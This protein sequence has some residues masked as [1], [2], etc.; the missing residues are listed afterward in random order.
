MQ[1]LPLLLCGTHSMQIQEQKHST[2]GAQRYA[3]GLKRSRGGGFVEEVKR[4]TSSWEV[5][6]VGFST[7]QLNIITSIT[8]AKKRLLLLSALTGHPPQKHTTFLCFPVFS[9]AATAAGM[10]P[11]EAPSFSVSH[12][13]SFSC[14]LPQVARALPRLHSHL[15][16][17]S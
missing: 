14:L 11:G 1:P 4:R 13:S 12:T 8:G 15:Q 3:V 9:R 2:R 10:P 5:R 16:P 17:L 7:N 6:N